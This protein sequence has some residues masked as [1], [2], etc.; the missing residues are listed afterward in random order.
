MGSTTVVW[1]V[2][3]ESGNT[4]TCEIT[5]VVE[6]NEAPVFVNCPT[7]PVTI[8]ADSDCSNGV[9]WSIPVAEDNCEVMSVVE[10]SAGG[11]Y[12][13]TDLT[14][15]TYEIEYTA[16]DGATPANTAVCTFTIIVEDDDESRIWYVSLI[17][18]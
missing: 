12:F 13:G 8:G 15:G 16:T 5:V 9:V 7:G 10:T 17:L 11:P 2:T 6:D 4:A 18:R 3:D 14:P 1:T